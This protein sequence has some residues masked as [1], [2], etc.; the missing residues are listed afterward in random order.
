MNL[1]SDHKSAESGARGDLPEVSFVVPVYNERESLRPLFEEIRRAGD[2]QKLSYE[3]LFVDD[4]STDGSDAVLF[5]LASGDPRVRVASFRRNFGK[6]AALAIAFAR[7][8]G[9][10]VMTLDAD[11][12]DDPA[13]LGNLLRVMKE[14]GYDLVSG[15]KEKRHDP[16]TKTL[17]SRLFNEVTGRVT[18]TRIH[19]LNCG[20]KLYRR[21]VVESIDV[22]G[23]LHRFLPALANW[24]GFKVGEA[25]VRHR[26]RK[27]GRSKFGAA[28]FLNGFLD[29][30]AVSFVQTSALKPLH[31]F[32]RISLLLIALGG[33]IEF[34][35]LVL[36][37][38]GEPLRV[39][40][41]LVLG[42]VLVIVGI[43]FASMG[44]LGELIATQHSKTDFPLRAARNWHEPG[45]EETGGVA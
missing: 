3:I 30:M 33:L 42:A 36:W 18:R 28:R 13:E 5:D 19:D 20:L 44:L 37:L 22:Y 6:S 32:G 25:P 34:Y 1:E 27:F 11:L 23:E 41:L 7:V 12:Q 17:P 31:V 29:L 8:R 15:W 24:K 43:Q 26:A 9:R 2:S 4:G 40:P 39:R 45:S 16:W 38:G 35:F 21:E 10:Y 14:G